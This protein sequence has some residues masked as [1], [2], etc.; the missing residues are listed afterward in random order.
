MSDIGGVGMSSRYE[1]Y[2]QRLQV[3]NEP[4]RTESDQNGATGGS[5]KGIGF[6]AQTQPAAEPSL[7]VALQEAG[8]GRDTDEDEDSGRT[9]LFASEEEDE[10]SRLIEEILEVGFV[11]WAHEQWLEKIREKARETALANLGMT[12]D[13]LAQ[14]A[15][16]M[17][18]QIERLIE[19]LVEAAINSATEEAAK[20]K[21]TGQDNDAMVLSPILT[22]G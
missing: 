3:F 2:R 8:F 17:Q 6:G 16:E 10:Q 9:G 19:E 22:G 4:I 1:P 12:E 14:M 21:E 7:L 5:E 13:D 15:P 20:N 18:E 11:D